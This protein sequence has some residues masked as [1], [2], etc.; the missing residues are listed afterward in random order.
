[1]YAD[2]ETPN[3]AHLSGT[4]ERQQAADVVYLSPPEEG[5][6]LDPFKVHL[7]RSSFATETR[8]QEAS[9]WGFPFHCA[10]WDILNSISP[11]NQKRDTQAILDLCRS[12]PVQRGILNFGH[13]YDGCVQTNPYDMTPLDPTAG[14][15]SWLVRGMTPGYMMSD[16]LRVPGLRDFFQTAEDGGP[17]SYPTVDHACEIDPIA[18]AFSELPATLLETIL[19]YLPSPDVIRLKQASRVF[20]NVALTD[21]FWRSRFL[22]GRELGSLFES[23]RHLTASSLRGQ[24]KRLFFSARKL[25]SDAHVMNRKRVWNLALS[26]DNLLDKVT[27]STCD[28]Q[29]VRSLS[30]PHAVADY[31]HWETASRSLKPATSAFTSGSRSLCER[32]TAIP[33]EVE[34]VFVSTVEV[35]GRTYISGIRLQYHGGYSSKLGYIRPQ[36]EYPITWPVSSQSPIAGFHLAQDERG[37]RGLAV[38][39]SGDDVSNWI[40]DYEG[41]PKRRLALTSAS[42][43]LS[44]GFLKGGFDVSHLK[45]SM[46]SL[47]VY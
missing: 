36:T 2:D 21:P 40:G 25:D 37:I 26:L 42:E 6:Q 41:F 22:P 39:S 17:Q 11:R 38:L 19:L 20:A 10:C 1:M 12:Y 44:V 31:M 32:I 14:D 29:P 3:E 16:P 5:S 33:Y 47:T 13:D 4:G 28:G 46:N 9:R 30:E 43:G 24:W 27:G 35:Y 34:V 18:D 23:D 45:S 7:M 15:D 8:P